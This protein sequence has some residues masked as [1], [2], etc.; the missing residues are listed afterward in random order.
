MG[1]SAHAHGGFFTRA[2]RWVWHE[3]IALLPAIGYFFVAFSILTVNEDLVLGKLEL[4]PADLLRPLVGALLVSKILLI[5]NM[6]SLIDKFP[7]KPLIWGV[8]RKT[9][10]YWL[11]SIL[12]QLVETAV[13]HL[14]DGGG[15]AGAIGGVVDEA[16]G[17][18]FILVQ[19]W[20]FVLL[21]VFVT[22]QQLILAVGAQRVREMFFGPAK[23]AG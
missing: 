6:I 14:L 20:L 1:R 16:S 7:D 19:M 2:W 8:A 23:S 21:A 5:A 9:L 4:S 22:L 17:S 3:F 15:L 10:V 11:L 12:F 13:D 18:R